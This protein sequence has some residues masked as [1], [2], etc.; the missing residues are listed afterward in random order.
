MAKSVCMW[1]TDFLLRLLLVS[2]VGKKMSRIFLFLTALLVCA[3]GIEEIGGVDNVSGGGVWGGMDESQASPGGFHKVCYVTALDYQKGYDWRA[4]QARENVRCSLVV[5]ADGVPVMKLPVGSAYE[6]SSDPDMHRIIDGHLY[7]DYSTDEETVIKKDG[8]LMF[9]YQ[10]RESLCGMKIIG[11]DLYTLGQSRDGKGFAFRRNGEILLKKDNGTVMGSLNS[12]G[13]SLFFA[14]Y[15][16]IRN[17][18]GN[19]GRYYMS[20]NS[21][22]KQIA[23]REDIKDVWDIL[24]NRDQVTYLASLTGLREPVLIS[25]ESMTALQLPQGASLS[26]CRLI[27][28]G[29]NL[30]AEGIC[31]HNGD[32]YDALWINGRLLTVFPKNRMVTSLDVSDN[33]VFCALNPTASDVNGIIHR[34][35]E[36]YSMPKGYSALGTSCVKVIDGILHVGL[37]SRNGRKPLIWKDGVT[38]SLKVNGYITSIYAEP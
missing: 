37:S 19:V 13:D 18:E 6:T 1:W 26:A 14:F 7:T 16:L 24:C 8:A 9:R 28:S 11:E 17:A 10:G 5:F 33:G 38:D 20:V 27:R 4:D 3:C 36:D 21:K 29:D 31:H 25:G 15:E 23:L 30:L 32:L 2:F 35:G 34:S 12:E 22:V